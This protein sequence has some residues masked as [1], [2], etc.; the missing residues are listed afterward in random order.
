MLTYVGLAALAALII[1]LM[2]GYRLAAPLR[3][4]HPIA[5]VGIGILGIGQLAQAFR[6]EPIYLHFTPWMWTGFILLVDG[7]NYRLSGSS[8]VLSRRSA[9]WILLPFSV[10]FWVLFEAYNL[11]LVNWTYIGLP[12]NLT[13]RYLS[14]AWAFSTILPAIFEASELYYNLFF[15]NAVPHRPLRVGSGLL[16]ASILCG[17]AFLVV[18]PLFTPEVA[19]FFFG[20][21]W[22]GVIFAFDPWNYRQDRRSLFR[23]LERGSWGRIAALWWGGVLCGFLW[24]FWNYW[25]H[26]KWVYIFPILQDFK[27]FEMPVLGYLGFPFFALECFVICEL[28][29]GKRFPGF[30]RLEASPLSG[31]QTQLSP[32]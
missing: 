29:L 2:Y 18:P 3:R 10:L 28:V 23:D 14:Y 24:E 5:A 20:F 17:I 8:L 15:R 32:R 22:M 30:A 31:A 13:H 16:I 9:F 21:V 19:G 26:A 7:L 11:R 27:V 6:I 4:W 25:A 12:D 1:Q